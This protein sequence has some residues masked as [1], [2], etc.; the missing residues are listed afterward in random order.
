MDLLLKCGEL[1]RDAGSAL[2]GCAQTDPPPER[3]NNDGDGECHRGD[4]NIDEINRH[5]AT[6][7]VSASL[8]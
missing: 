1:S 6:M 7:A 4:R 5:E 8:R 2:H 3:L